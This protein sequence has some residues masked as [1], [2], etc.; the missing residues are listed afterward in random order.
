MLA[1]KLGVLAQGTGDSGSRLAPPAAVGRPDSIA[2]AS[3]PLSLSEGFPTLPLVS[4]SFLGPGKLA[5]SLG[6][7]MEGHRGLPIPAG[8]FGVE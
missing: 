1:A 7:Q 8:P 4:S 5:S 3:L 6:L 2:E